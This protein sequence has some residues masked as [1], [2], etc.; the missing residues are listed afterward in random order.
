MG[1]FSWA[2]IE[3]FWYISVF[4]PAL[5]S[6]SRDIMLYSDSLSSLSFAQSNPEYFVKLPDDK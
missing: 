1:L 3:S 4:V 5:N 2:L 6:A